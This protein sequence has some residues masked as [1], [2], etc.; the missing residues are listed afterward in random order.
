MSGQVNCHCCSTAG[1]SG[2][3]LAKKSECKVE[4]AVKAND[5]F[6]FAQAAEIWIDLPLLVGWIV[7][8]LDRE[9]EPRAVEPIPHRARPPDLASRLLRAPP[10]A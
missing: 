3:T 9:R 10:F 4:V 1:N 7:L 6:A 8:P 2:P 5:V